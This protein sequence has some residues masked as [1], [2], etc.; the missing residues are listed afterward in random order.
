MVP[1]NPDFVIVGAGI[2]GLTIARALAERKCGSVLILEKE[3][4]LGLHASGRNSGVLHTGI[5]YGADSLKARF[6]SEGARKMRAY[7]AEKGIPVLQT[8][9]VIVA[10]TPESAAGIDELLSR[11]EAN[12]A[13]ARKITP[14]E[15]KKLEPEAHT[16]GAAL[17]SPETAVIDSLKVLESLERELESRGVTILKSCPVVGLDAKERSLQT[18]KEKFGYGHLINTSGLHAD[19]VAHWMGVG[20]KYGILPFKGIYYKLRPEAAARFRGAIYPVPNPAMPFLGVHITRTVHQEVILGPTAIPALGRE[21]YGI[22]KG[23]DLRDVPQ[24]LSDLL[25]MFAGNISGFRN[26]VREE[27]PHYARA[28]FLKSVQK[29]AP[30]LQEK[31]VEPKGY[32]VGLRAQLV[33][34]KTLR[35]VMD[36]V[37]EDGPHST[38]ILNAV[39]PAFTASMAFAEMIT[40]K[41]QNRA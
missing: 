12:G 28:G 6:C 33:E 29:L 11:A 27:I 34:R 24:I 5:Y 22:L 41:I 10:P 35:L 25:R 13:R 7:A 31:D 3:E 38:H 26:L 14:E 36:F 20:E 30:A 1:K 15:L 17:F 39:S 37:V 9:K 2:V 32:K 16:C 23:L 4:A 21:N 8:G 40:D 18:P 19:R